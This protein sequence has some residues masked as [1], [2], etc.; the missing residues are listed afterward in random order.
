MESIRLS[1]IEDWEDENLED[2]LLKR[3]HEIN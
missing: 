1:E 3:K 2:S